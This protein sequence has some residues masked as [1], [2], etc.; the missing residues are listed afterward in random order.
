VARH[1]GAVEVGGA[2][3]VALEAAAGALAALELVVHVAEHHQRQR[4]PAL[5]GGDRHAE[6]LVAPVTGG[7]LPVAAAGIGGLAAQ[8][9]RAAV[10]QQHQRQPGVGGGG[11]GLDAPGR[12]LQ[13]GLAVHGLHPG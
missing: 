6:V 4:A 12:L 8:A 9:G 13:A 5:D 2:G 11:G 10:G 1:T 3:A 7:F